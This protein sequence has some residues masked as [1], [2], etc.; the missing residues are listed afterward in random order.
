MVHYGGLSA[1]MW[2]MRWEPPYKAY[3]RYKYQN[4]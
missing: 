1:A 2:Q 4:P 3:W